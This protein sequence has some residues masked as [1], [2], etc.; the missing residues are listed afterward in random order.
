MA[1]ALLVGLI[2]PV[3][4]TAVPSAGNPVVY[5]SLDGSGAPAVQ[6]F[7]MPGADGLQLH[8]FID[9]VNNPDVG[10]SGGLG[11]MCV[12]EDGDETCGF[13]VLI[14]MTTDTATFSAFAPAVAGIIGEIDSNT[15]TSLH[16]NGINV[17]GMPIPAEIGTL[18]LDAL[19]ANQFQ[20]EVKGVHRVGAAGQLDTIQPQV[21]V[22]VPEPG[23]LLQ[24][25][26]GAAGLAALRRFRTSYQ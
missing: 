18:T 14:E 17:G 10:A 3:M 4:A 25:L 20:I 8:L 2:L 7:A 9:Y 22:N 15:Q 1:A 26:C 19:G 11:T 23:R 16:V 12:D 5:L 24:L 21:I 13:D 6:P